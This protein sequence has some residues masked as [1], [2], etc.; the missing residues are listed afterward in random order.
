[1]P[2]RAN[3]TAKRLTKERSGFGN[4]TSAVCYVTICPTGGKDSNSGCRTNANVGI[5]EIYI[6]PTIG[7]TVAVA[8]D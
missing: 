7:T 2:Q 4:P 8:S 5:D 3:V 6:F 1:M